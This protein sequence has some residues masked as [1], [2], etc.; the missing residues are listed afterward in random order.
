MLQSAIAEFCATKGSAAEAYQ[1][2]SIL[3]ELRARKAH[4][5]EHIDKLTATIEALEENPDINPLLS[6]LRTL[7]MF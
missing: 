6:N 4:Y 5:Q 3:D 7:G 1:R 2:P